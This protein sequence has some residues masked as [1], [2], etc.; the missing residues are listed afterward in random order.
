M[1]YRSRLRILPLATLSVFL[2]QGLATG[3]FGQ[4]D[5]ESAELRSPAGQRLLWALQVTQQGAAINPDSAFVPSFFDRIPREAIVEGV[6]DVAEESGGLTLESVWESDPHELTAA[7]RA[8]GDSA[9]WRIVVDVEDRAPHRLT[10]LSYNHAPEFGA[11][12][13]PNWEALDGMLTALGE[14]AIFAAYSVEGDSLR[15]LHLKDADHPVAIAST[16]KLWVLGA[17]A[18]LVDEGGASW[19][20]PLAIR[21]EWKTLPSGRMQNLPEGETRSLAEF[22]AQMVS[23][24]DNTA[25]DHLIHRIGRERVAD[26]AARHGSPFDRNRPFLTVNELFKLKINAGVELMEQYGKGTPDVR[27]HIL[28]EQI[29]AL[30]TPSDSEEP[31]Q[32]TAIE[33][34]EWFASANALA[35]LIVH[36]AE[37]GHRPG[38]EPVW[39]ALTRNPGFYWNRNTWPIVAYKGGLEAGVVNLAW[40]MER[41]DG[42]RFVMVLGV[43]DT[44]HVPDRTGVVMAAAAAGKLLEREN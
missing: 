41:S 5:A 25:T 15:P 17:V 22:A 44:R 2:A 19:T 10:R 40:L 32:P 36:L 42:R 28:V 38:Q 29:A 11:P 35:G 30:P 13:L 8:V 21:D 20:E 18:E 37:V 43:N 7:A 34:I 16:F 14:T 4:T 6:T 26:Y 3:A 31:E 1:A 33:T 23:I 9:W 12:A 24:S 27:R 39:D